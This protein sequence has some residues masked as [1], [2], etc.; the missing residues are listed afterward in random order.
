MSPS[1]QL[2]G[3]N[4]STPRAATPRT[5]TTRLAYWLSAAA[6]IVASIALITNC[7]NTNRISDRL[8][9]A[10]YNDT[11]G[12]MVDLKALKEY[13]VSTVGANKARYAVLARLLYL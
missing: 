10:H 5:R 8:I 2:L 4:P 1:Y 6:L 3:S 13:L 12:N 11:S 9:G 7:F